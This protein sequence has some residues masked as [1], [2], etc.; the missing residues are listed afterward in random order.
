MEDVGGDGK[1]KTVL[2]SPA[3]GTSSFI[4]R[5]YRDDGRIS[6]PQCGWSQ[7]PREAKCRHMGPPRS[8]YLSLQRQNNNMSLKDAEECMHAKEK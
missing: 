3:A 2:K 1:M 4:G 6:R 8:S 5:R 7:L